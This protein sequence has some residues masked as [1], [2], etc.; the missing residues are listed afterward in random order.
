[1]KDIQ[2]ERTKK[3]K[4]LKKG[5]IILGTLLV[6][7][8][9]ALILLKSIDSKANKLFLNEKEV[10][11]DRLMYTYEGERYVNI[12]EM[13][14]LFPTFTYSTGEYLSDGTVNQDPEYFHLKSLYEVIQFKKESDQISKIIL[15]DQNYYTYDF[16]G[17]RVLT[18]EE[19]SKGSTSVIERQE[20]DN[21]KR[22]TEDFQLQSKVLEI[23]KNQ[24]I[25]LLDI[26][27]VFNVQVS[28]VGNSIKL[29]TVEYLESLYS[30]TLTRNNLYLNPNY[31]NRRAILDGYF[32]TTTNRT[33]P[34]YGVQIYENGIFTSQISESYK[35]IRYM[36]TNKTIFVI[37]KQNAFGLINIDKAI[38]IIK[39][40]LYE[41]IEA[42]YS[43]L[44]LYQVKNVQGKLGI[45]EASGVDTVKQIVH[46]EYDQIG[47]DTSKF[48]GQTNGKV[49]FNSLI[50][51]KKDNKW[52]IFD[53]KNP[54]KNYGSNIGGYIDLGYKSPELLST[55]SRNEPE[56]T[57][58]QVNELT[59]RGFAYL[60][61]VDRNATQEEKTLRLLELE[62]EGFVL[63]NNQIPEGESTLVVPESSG[64]GGLIVKSNLSGQYVYYII[65]ADAGIRATGNPYA[66]NTP[67]KRIYKYT[68]DGVDKY[69]AISV[70]TANTKYELRKQEE[71]PK[72]QNKEQNTE[73]E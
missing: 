43:D 47:Y 11:F 30:S 26:K 33:N 9:A 50:P 57:T 4:M 66:L 40:G 61:K 59:S 7:L 15:I 16:N 56:F 3:E 48:L 70:D 60:T 31:Q 63:S 28:M 73:T 65:S 6:L 42:Y 34:V 46:L 64:F 2:E 38:D 29:Y 69:Y 37:N 41:S 58:S 45:I 18:K 10:S 54:G 1:M 25:P 32:I 27:Y 62:R 72:E 36:Q 52:Y 12:R 51:A 14:R 22:S 20:I 53:L 24:Y 13:E 71:Q 44:D 68:T 8:V 19:S 67:Y 5:L 55:N 39:P 23:G 49:F 17:N 35:D 21:K